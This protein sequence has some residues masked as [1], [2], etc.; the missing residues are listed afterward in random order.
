VRTRELGATL[1]C[2]AAVLLMGALAACRERPP[3]PPAPVPGPPHASWCVDG[4]RALDEETCFVVPEHLGAPPAVV[5]FAHGMVAPDTT[6]RQEMEIVRDAAIARGFVAVLPRG[7]P[8][9]C[10]WKPEVTSHYCWPTRRETVDAEAQAI[11]AR[12]ADAQARI[13]A[14]TFVSFA[15]RYVLGFSNGGYFAAY[16][17]LEGLLPV[18]GVGVVGAGRTAVDESRTGRRRPPF[19]LAVGD[20]EA[21]FTQA[22]AEH[23]ASLLSLREWPIEYVIHPGR[24]HELRADDLDAAW[25][26][27]Q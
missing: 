10:A 19:Y 13:E 15:R 5:F 26:T 23:L 25:L 14:I 27:W 4:A 9:L 6:P 16:L 20:K 2:R 24:G 17:G 1:H 21:D 8:G 11:L 18:D 12:W 22:D 3:P 7:S